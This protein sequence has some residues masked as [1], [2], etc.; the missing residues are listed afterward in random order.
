M[1]SNNSFSNLNNVNSKIYLLDTRNY[2]WIT[3]TSTSSNS[4]HPQNPT[5]TQ[6]QTV[7]SNPLSTGAIVVI[8]SVLI[9]VLAIAGFAGYWFYKKKKQNDIIRIA[10][11]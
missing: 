8:P 5:V 6:I 9:A 1:M 2:N 3:S 11:S 4:P 7:T 10:G